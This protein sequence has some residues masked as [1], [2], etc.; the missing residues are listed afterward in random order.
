L[1]IRQDVSSLSADKMPAY[2]VGLTTD[3][4]MLY[5]D[6]PGV[7]EYFTHHLT[8]YKIDWTEI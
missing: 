1:T 5:A 4:K 7:K 3:Y 8:N 2:R 6:D